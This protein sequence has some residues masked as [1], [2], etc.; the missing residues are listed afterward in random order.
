MAVA[1]LIVRVVLGG[2]FIAAGMR[3]LGRPSF[4]EVVRAYRLL[5]SSASVAVA[6]LLPV[7]EIGVG[8]ALVLGLWTRTAALLVL[9]LLAAFAVA[10]ISS[11][12][13]GLRHGCGCAGSDRP[14]PV[15]W[16]LVGR[17]F[18]LL[19]LATFAAWAPV[20]VALTAP[21]DQVTHLL[22]WSPDQ[23]LAVAV[24]VIL[25]GCVPALLDALRT[26]IHVDRAASTGRPA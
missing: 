4:V 24:A 2:L 17:D 19:G 1:A 12:L 18:C 11:L 21:G 10:A 22:R 26:V 3:K 9:G 13:R 15:S 5:P 14:R 25:L 16:R 8:L 7:V 6:R 20:R 23:A